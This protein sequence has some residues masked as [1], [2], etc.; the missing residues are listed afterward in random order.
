MEEQEKQEVDGSCS[1]EDEDREENS[2]LN[3]K[4]WNGIDELESMCM[5]CG[6]TG[7]TRFMLHKIPY[8]RELILASFVCEEC[9]ERNNEVTFGG[10]IQ[11]Q[12]C[13][14]NLYVMAPKDLDRQI[15][16]SDSASIKI[17]EIDFEIPPMT[18]K[19]EIN[20]IEGILRTA[21][22]NLQ[23]GQP[24]RM[25]EAPEIAAKVGEIIDKLNEMADG[26]M[27]PF[28]LALD[29]PAGNSFIQNP[30][31][32][33]VD[34]HMS[35]AHY[36]R[37]EEQDRFLGLDPTKGVYK[38]EKDTAVNSFFAGR[39]KFGEAP[40]SIAQQEPNNEDLSSEMV[41]LGRTEAASLPAQC[42]N[43][44]QAGESLTALTDIP[45]FK[46]VSFLDLDYV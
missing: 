22:K 24:I 10:E 41:V 18:Q 3:Y 9:G 5:R 29:D 45:H 12:G 32:P 46:E 13:V 21:A 27:L 1:Q 19:G 2:G 16:K 35:I 11:L 26:S 42:P 4:E 43:C 33:K 6:S 7:V 14:Y 15:I 36:N 39:R 40:K 25:I 38:D 20:T 8:F 28:S 34:P 44:C 17:K 37:S 31:V 30:H 23:F